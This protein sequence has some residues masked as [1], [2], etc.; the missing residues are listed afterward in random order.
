VRPLY[1][2][3]VVIMAL[4]LPGAAAALALMVSLVMVPHSP[5]DVHAVLAPHADTA[6]KETNAEPTRTTTAHAPK[7]AP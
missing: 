7:E 2:P 6:P 3:A 1:K 5:Q 4:A